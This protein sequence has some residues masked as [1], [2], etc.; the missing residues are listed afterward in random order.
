MTEVTFNIENGLPCLSFKVDGDFLTWQDWMTDSLNLLSYGDCLSTSQ[1]A[2]VSFQ[3]GAN[4]ATFSLK[5]EEIKALLDSENYL[6]VCE[7]VGKSYFYEGLMVKKDKIE[8]SGN[9][10]NGINLQA[11]GE[12]DKAI[13]AYK[14]VIEQSPDTPRIN[15]LLGLCYRIKKDYANAELAYQTAITI[16]PEHA[17][18]YSN[19]GIL[20]LKMGKEAE[21]E[22]LF[23]KA[24]ERDQFYLNALLQYSK[25]ISAKS[26]SSPQLVSS[27]N[28]RLLSAYSDLSIVQE[29]LTEVAQKFG[30]P[31]H[32]YITKLKSENG[33]MADQ[34]TMLLIKRTENLRI[35]GA[36]FAA[37][38]G[39]KM[40]L[41][42]C[43]NTPASNFIESWSASRITLMNKLI[44]SSM[45]QVW[46]EK[47]D[48]LL[49]QY[50][51]VK[52]Y[53]VDN[54][55]EVISSPLTSE[56][57]YA[58]VVFEMLRDGQIHPNQAKFLKNLQGLLKLSDEK[59]TELMQTVAKS[60]GSSPMGDREDVAFNPKRLFKNLVRAVFRDGKV[61]DSEKKIL[62]FASK[63]FGIN[64]DEV[65]KIVAEVRA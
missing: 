5:Q 2:L 23:A 54:P 49:E 29:H 25:L 28:L 10:L 42:K 40:L 3:T 63:A 27:L 55:Q 39:I 15:N 59:V 30:I 6:F 41:A 50:S 60:A 33:F 51:S 31:L 11:T 16:S 37:I 1:L 64:S 34:K 21:A 4:L 18:T 65:N 17:E 53:L 62:V 43:Q 46:K 35:N 26:D 52:K 47:I 36:I 38:Q 12:I 8:T 56:E 48:E 57:F 22:R 9:F 20:Y 19:L 13:E 24:L 32:E 45:K 58:Q 14:S 44:P 7:S 61:D